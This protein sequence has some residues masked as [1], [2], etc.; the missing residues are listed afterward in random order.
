[1]N[2]GLIGF[3]TYWDPAVLVVAIASAVGGSIAGAPPRIPL[4]TAI[5]FFA[6][7]MLIPEIMFLYRWTDQGGELRRRIKYLI[8]NQVAVIVIAV[9]VLAVRRRLFS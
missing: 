3:L 4:S 5:V 6:P 7:I 8:S 2:K 1:M 9:V